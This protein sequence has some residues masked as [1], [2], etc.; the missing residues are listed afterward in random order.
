MLAKETVILPIRDNLGQVQRSSHIPADKR[1]NVRVV[2][3]V[4]NDVRVKNPLDQVR[5]TPDRMLAV[6][7]VTADASPLITVS[8]AM[9]PMSMSIKSLA[10]IE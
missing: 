9:L 6:T 5:C 3:K 7:L 1:A 4:V 10:G 8:A 2:C